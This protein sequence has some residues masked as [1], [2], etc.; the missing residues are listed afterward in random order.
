M[1]LCCC[2]EDTSCRVW[3]QVIL[4]QVDAI[5]L[6]C[7][8]QIRVIIHDQCCAIARNAAKLAPDAQHAVGRRNLVAILN[9][10]SAGIHQLAGESQDCSY[11]IRLCGE[12]GEIDDGVELGKLHRLGEQKPT[13]ETRT[14]G[15]PK[16]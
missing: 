14:H 6:S 13:T 5:G 3:T 16:K 11:G 8:T 12:A 2:E 10:G 7:Q 1:R 9:E 15:E 4:T